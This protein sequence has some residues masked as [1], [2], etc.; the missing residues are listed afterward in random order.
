LF[1]LQQL[2]TARQPEPHI[3]CNQIS[4]AWFQNKARDLYAL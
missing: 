4:H 1:N 3:L 2:L